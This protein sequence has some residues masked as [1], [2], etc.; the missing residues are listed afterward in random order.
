MHRFALAAAL[1]APVISHADFLTI[2]LPGTPENGGWSGLNSTNYSATDG[3]TGNYGNPTVDWPTPLSAVTGSTSAVF[4][5]VDGTSGYFGGSSVYTPSGT[6]SYT[7]S[8]SSPMAD[9]STIVFQLDMDGSILSGPT[10]TYTYSG[11]SDTL[12]LSGSTTT[13]G[14]YGGFEGGSTTIYVWQWDLSGIAETITGYSIDWTVDTHGALYAMKL[15]TS[16]AYANAVPEPSTYAAL[17]GLGVLGF[18]LL[19]RRKLSQK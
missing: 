9:L 11:G 1:L 13:T 17:A 14:N 16:N 6:G 8:D 10:L 15:D 4:D 3:Y 7:M 2:S 12:S 18:A 19:R 5:K